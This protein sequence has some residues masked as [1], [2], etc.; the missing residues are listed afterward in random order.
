MIKLLTYSN[1]DGA[2]DYRSAQR[3]LIDRALELKTIDTHFDAT[4]EMIEQTEFY[5]KNRGILDQKRGG[6]YWLFKPYYILECLKSESMAEGDI[7]IYI[8]C[9]DFISCSFR[10]FVE[11]KMKT[12]DI[13]LTDGGAKHSDYCKRDAFILMNVDN[14]AFHNTLQV[15]AGIIVCK[16]SAATIKFINNWLAWCIIPEVVTDMPNTQGENLLGFLDHRHDQSVLTNLKNIYHLHSSSEM[17]Q[18]INCNKN[19]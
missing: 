2:L 6:G 14:Y 13:L 11:E 18:F 3:R 7:L 17:R 15:E 5:E 4:R 12:T 8:D 9:G 19:Q 1:K 10:K 16:K